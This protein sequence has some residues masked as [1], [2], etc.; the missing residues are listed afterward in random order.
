MIILENWTNLGALML[1]CTSILKCFS[2]VLKNQTV[3]YSKNYCEK[4]LKFYSFNGS[5]RIFCKVLLGSLILAETRSRSIWACE[6]C[7][8]GI[9]LSCL[10]F[11]LNFDFFTVHWLKLKIVRERD[12]IQYSISSAKIYL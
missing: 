5:L 4:T 7:I 1:Y 3:F 9:C 10:S 8:Y 2:P 11:E 12:S 6:E